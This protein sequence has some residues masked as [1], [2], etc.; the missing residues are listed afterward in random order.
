MVSPAARPRPS[1]ESLAFAGRIWKHAL[2][3]Q[4][5]LLLWLGTRYPWNQI[6]NFILL[7]WDDLGYEV[8]CDIAH[9]VHALNELFAKAARR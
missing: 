2:A 7:A 9:E 4:A 1:A 6:E 3:H 5:T 8:Q